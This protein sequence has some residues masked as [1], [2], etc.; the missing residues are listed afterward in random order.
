MGQKRVCW[1]SF[2]AN[3]QSHATKI[4]PSYFTLVYT[5]L[6][7]RDI[8]VWKEAFA[9]FFQ[10]LSLPPRALSKFSQLCEELGQ[11]IYE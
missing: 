4:S 9:T 1:A 8:T 2:Q 6:Y 7:L 10:L 5:T 11:L 3:F